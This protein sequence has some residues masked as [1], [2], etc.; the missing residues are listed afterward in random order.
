MLIG[1][2]LLTWHGWRGGNAR[3]PNVYVAKRGNSKSVARETRLWMT[4]MGKVE[5]SSDSVKPLHLYGESRLGCYGPFWPN[6]EQGKAHEYERPGNFIRD[7]S[8]G[9]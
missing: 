2:D 9:P 1:L 4:R 3:E 8:S 5:I 7:S 6:T